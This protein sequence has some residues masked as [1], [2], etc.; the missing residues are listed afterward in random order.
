MILDTMV[1]VYACFD[2]PEKSAASRDLLRKVRTTHAP[3]SF[4]AEFLNA[5]WQ[6]ARTYSIHPSEVEGLIAD[7]LSLPT[8]YIGIEPLWRDA[9]ALA[10][11]ANHSP[12]D[13]LFVAAARM[14]RTRVLTFDERMIKLFPKYCIHVIDHLS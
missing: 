2:V 11:E 5:A 9:I 1:A 6:Y 7:G 12:Y 3:V 13:A 4:Q 10:L 8:A 14:K